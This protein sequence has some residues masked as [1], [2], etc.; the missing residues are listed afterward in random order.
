MNSNQSG[1]SG[2]MTTKVVGIVGPCGAGKSTLVKGLQILG[3]RAK[4]IAQ[5]HSYVPDMWKR[6]TSPDILIYLD[7]S[8]ESTIQRLNLNW[9][10]REYDKQ[11]LRLTHAK[12]YSDIYIQTDL[13]SIE[14]V[15]KTVVDT[16]N[17]LHTEN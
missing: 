4:H 1:E 6:L 13:L 17:Q 15:L 12:E 5:E 3:I 9:T 2:F 10:K 8:Y 7:V 16:L 14:Q 11:L